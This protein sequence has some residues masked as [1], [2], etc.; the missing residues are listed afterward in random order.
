MR[1]LTY[2]LAILA[3]F[4]FAHRT[5]DAAIFFGYGVGSGGEPVA[6]DEIFVSQ[7]GILTISVYFVESPGDTRLTDGGVASFNFFADFNT[8]FGNV[9]S[10]AVRSELANH[11]FVPPIATVNAGTLHLAGTPITF[12]VGLKPL[13]AGPK[14]VELGTIQLNVT[15]P[16]ITTFNNFRGPIAEDNGL[17]GDAPADIVFIDNEIFAG[18]PTLIVN[19]TAIPEPSSVLAIAGIIGLGAI[20]VRRRRR[21]RKVA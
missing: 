12:P 14:R 20:R 6:G 5:A 21:S 19:S 13:P 17:G 4:A 7:R 18:S 10:V 15:G 16:G 8:D 11:P 3:C 9:E 1:N 2:S